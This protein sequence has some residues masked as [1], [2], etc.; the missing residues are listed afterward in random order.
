[1]RTISLAAMLMATPAAA[2][3]A[4][5]RFDL[6]CSGTKEW[7]GLRP[8]EPTTAMAQFRLRIDLDSKKF[9]YDSCDSILDI[10]TVG[11][12][13]LFLGGDGSTGSAEHSEFVDRTS[14]RYFFLKSWADDAVSLTIKA[15]CSPERFSGFPDPP[16]KF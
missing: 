15:S 12:K 9:C 5:Q 16:A 7:S 2:A 11:A 8:V 6:V 14:G 4:E 3:T 13:A 10:T 1:M